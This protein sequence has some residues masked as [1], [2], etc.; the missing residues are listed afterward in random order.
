MTNFTESNPLPM[1]YPAT[2]PP[3]AGDHV[4]IGVWPNGWRF[5]TDADRARFERM[6]A[7]RQAEFRR[8]FDAQATAI[9]ER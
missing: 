6:D 9:T 4:D 7:D 3:V 5:I 8:A 1:R 2:T